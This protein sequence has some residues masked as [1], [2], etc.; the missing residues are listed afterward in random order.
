[1]F[2]TMTWFFL[3]VITRNNNE[4]VIKGLEQSDVVILNTGEKPPNT[5]KDLFDFNYSR[6][7]VRPNGALGSEADGYCKKNDTGWGR[8]YYVLQTGKLLK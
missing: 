5:V 1:M 4:Q 2:F 6:G 3:P 7:S 8:A